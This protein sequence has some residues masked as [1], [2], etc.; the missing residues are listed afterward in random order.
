MATMSEGGKK[1]RPTTPISQLA[2]QHQQ[3]QQ[4]F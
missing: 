2:A 4:T 1:L 3:K